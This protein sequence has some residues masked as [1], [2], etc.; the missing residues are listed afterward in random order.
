[1]ITRN[2]AR[3]AVGLVSGC[4]KWGRKETQERPCMC[5]PMLWLL[6]ADGQVLVCFHTQFACQSH[7]GRTGNLSHTNNHCL[8]FPFYHFFLSRGTL[9][10]PPVFPCFNL[11][12]RNPKQSSCSQGGFVCQAP[13]P[14]G[15]PLLRCPVL[16]GAVSHRNFRSEFCQREIVAA[17]FYCL[18]TRCFISET[19]CLC[20][21]LNIF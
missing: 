7:L 11:C 19:I 13:E 14:G 1:M 15:G 3:G 17:K 18:K 9:I 16:L 20:L 5:S 4:F 2:P 8:I 21:T 6:R 10:S 12:D